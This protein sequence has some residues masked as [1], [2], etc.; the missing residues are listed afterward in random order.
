MIAFVN[1]A[2]LVL[3]GVNLSRKWFA[4]V[5]CKLLLLL[6]ARTRLIVLL[7]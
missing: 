7:I 4:S 3:Y 6:V 5:L 1:S 2:V